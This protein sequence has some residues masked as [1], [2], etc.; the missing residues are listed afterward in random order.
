MADEQFHEWGILEVM[1]RLRMAGMISEQTIAGAS[2]LRIDVPETADAPAF[3][4]FFT[5]GSIYSIT[6]T[7]EDIARGLAERLRE[8]PVTRFDLP[9]LSAPATPPAMRAA[10][11]G[12]DA[13]EDDLRGDGDENGEDEEDE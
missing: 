6:P 5:P 12:L 2:M 3:T 8:M 13:G 11:V 7:S 9:Q 4:R 10:F 1:G